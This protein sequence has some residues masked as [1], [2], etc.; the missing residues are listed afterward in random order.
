MENVDALNLKRMSPSVNVNDVEFA[1][2]QDIQRRHSKFHTIQWVPLEVLENIFNHCF[3]DEPRNVW[4]A[5]T[6]LLDMDS[7]RLR[8]S[9]TRIAFVGPFRDET[10]PYKQYINKCVGK[11]ANSPIHVTFEVRRSSY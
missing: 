7:G 4:K 2:G 9:I 1:M 10:A 8:V 11:S 3:N 5:S 6:R